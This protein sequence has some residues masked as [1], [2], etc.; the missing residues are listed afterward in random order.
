MMQ[1]PE[2]PEVKLLNFEGGKDHPELLNNKGIYT[3]IGKN[4][5]P[6]FVEQESYDTFQVS[7]GEAT[8]LPVGDVGDPNHMAQVS[9]AGV[10]EIGTRKKAPD[11][12][13]D[14]GDKFYSLTEDSD[15]SISDH[16]SSETGASISSE[17]GSISST[18]ES[19]VRKQRREHKGL[20]LRA[21]FR[22]GV[23]LSAQSRK[24]LKWDYSGTSLT[25]TA[26]V[27]ISEAQAKADVRVC[28]PDLCIGT[29]NTDSA[30]L[31]SIYNSIK[32]LQTET[33]VESRRA[34]MATKRLQGTVRKV[35]KSCIEIEE[36]LSKMEERMK[37]VEADVEALRAQ[38]AAHDGQ[39]ID[40]MWK[41]EDPENRQ[42]RNNLFFR[43]WRRGGGQ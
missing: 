4:M 2:V 32:E 22:D 11:W 9:E 38:S 19:T 13:K 28:S 33:R 7:Q 17:S 41:L 8:S 27:Y 5:Q 42:R 36:K 34:R 14:G 23:E 40:I 24:T 16:N 6:G 10:E 3:P 25:S 39:L 20:N 15:T 43:H 18:V 31:Q 26:E 21:P 30:M 35:V 12:S 29:R 37:A 1:G